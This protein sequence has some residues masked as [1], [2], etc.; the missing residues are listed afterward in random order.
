LGIRVH[1]NKLVEA[2]RELAFRVPKSCRT[3]QPH[4]FHSSILF[5]VCEIK[6]DNT[7]PVTVKQGKVGKGNYEAVVSNVGDL[8]ETV[9]APAIEDGFDIFG[10][11]HRGCIAR[12]Q[13]SFNFTSDET[14]ITRTYWYPEF[15]NVCLLE[16]LNEIAREPEINGTISSRAGRLSAQDRNNYKNGNQGHVTAESAF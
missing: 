4:P 2:D 3:T 8:D 10:L 16:I 7:L 12:P 6:A 13:I 1:Q 9:R 14:Q 11:G 5:T 15:V